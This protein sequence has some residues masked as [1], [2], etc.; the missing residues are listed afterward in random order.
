MTDYSELYATL[1]ELEK[2][3]WDLATK[4]PP[5][6]DIGDYCVLCEDM[7][8]LVHTPACPYRRA[9]EWKT[10]KVARWEAER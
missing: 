10:E 4:N 9:V 3:A 2:L 8:G 7:Y 6:D 5:L 1:T